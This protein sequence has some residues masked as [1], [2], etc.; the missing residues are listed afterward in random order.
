MC[1]V[2]VIP[3]EGGLRLVSNRDELR[4][5]PAALTPREHLAD[6]STPALWPID[7]TGGGT[8]IAVG[9]HGMAMSLLNLNLT[10][11]PKLPDA[12]TL[13]SRGTVIPRVL[14]A[15]SAK[16]AAD[17]ASH[18][19]LDRMNCFRLVCADAESVVCARW[20]STEFTVQEWG[21]EPV[22][23]ASSGLGDEIVQ[24]RLPLWDAML[25]EAGPTPEMQ[26]RYHA[27]TDDDAPERG[28]LMERELARTTSTT[29][30]EVDAHSVRI[31]HR[32]DHGW[33]EAMTLSRA[34][35]AEHHPR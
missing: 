18:L 35:P 12:R 26:D 21:L 17:R 30:T 5:R 14:G 13:V 20:D 22:C 6:E 16:E 31:H 4:T 19:E 28:V 25:A 1:T 7:P 24:S 23:F 2:T 8:W 9:A 27:T 3:T 29:V 10:P 15:A 33:H 11:H 34:H 32:D